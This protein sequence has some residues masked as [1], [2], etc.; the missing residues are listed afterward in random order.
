MQKHWSYL[1][2]P[3]IKLF[4]ARNEYNGQ[5]VSQSDSNEFIV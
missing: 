5:S 3:V 4:R 1:K 2:K